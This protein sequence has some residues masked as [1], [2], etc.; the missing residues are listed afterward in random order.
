MPACFGEIHQLP[1][2]FQLW[3]ERPFPIRI[4]ISAM[5]GHHFLYKPRRHYIAARVASMDEIAAVAV[6]VVPVDQHE[7]ESGVKM[8]HLSKVV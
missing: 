2:G 5:S 8:G 3:L 6:I 4:V 7:A 1:F